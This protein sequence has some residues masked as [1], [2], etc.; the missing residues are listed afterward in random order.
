[1]A[2]LLANTLGMT[3]QLQKNSFC[4]FFPE[5]FASLSSLNFGDQIAFTYI[6]RTRNAALVA[7]SSGNIISVCGAIGNEIES[8]QGKG[9]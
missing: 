9:W 1:V 8:R 3:C 5:N 7:W 6:A 2:A 4:S